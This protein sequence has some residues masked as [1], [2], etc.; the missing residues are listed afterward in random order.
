MEQKWLN[1]KKNSTNKLKKMN[2]II[3]NCW[4]EK[5]KN[6]QIFITNMMSSM[7]KK[8]SISKIKLNNFNPTQILNSNLN[9]QKNKINN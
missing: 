6:I 2:N 3:L 1:M 5:M 4:K 8:A 7:S 9:K